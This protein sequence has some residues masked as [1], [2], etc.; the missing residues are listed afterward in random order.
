MVTRSVWIPTFPRLCLKFETRIGKTF[1][2]TSLLNNKYYLHAPRHYSHNMGPPHL[3]ISNI[4]YLTRGEIRSP[5]CYRPKRR[6]IET[7]G[8]ATITA[9]TKQQMAFTKA[10]SSP[11]NNQA[12]PKIHQ[13]STIMRIYSWVIVH[14]TFDSRLINCPQLTCNTTFPI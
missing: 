13:F 1:S 9:W 14:L 11:N 3:L 8:S 6:N 5:R 2:I 10:P 12:L 4:H 7:G